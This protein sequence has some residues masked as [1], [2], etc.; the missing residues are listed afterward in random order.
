MDK[1]K[2]ADDYILKASGTTGKISEPDENAPTKEQAIINLQ[3]SVYSLQKDLIS[4]IKKLKDKYGADATTGKEEEVA[5]AM[6]ITKST[7]TTTTKTE[8]PKGYLDL[9][10]PQIAMLVAVAALQ[11]LG[12]IIVCSKLK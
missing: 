10:K 2:T 5:A 9:E 6:G 1:F 8:S 4:T 3:N 11:L 7:C 12:L